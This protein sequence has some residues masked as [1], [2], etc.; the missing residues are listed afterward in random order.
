VYGTAPTPDLAWERRCLDRMRRG[1]HTAFGELY[2]VFAPKL[3]REVLMP[4]L[5]HA[6]LAEDALAD[7]FSSFLEHHAQLEVRDQSLMAWLARVATNKALDMHR[8]RASLL[9]SLASFESLIGPLTA[10]PTTDGTYEDRELRE[11]SALQVAR[12][13]EALNPRYRRALELR[14]FQDEP[15][16]RCAELLEVKLGT[17]DVLLLRAL[18]AFRREWEL[19]VKA[20]EGGQ[21]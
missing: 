10:S 16:E 9:R 17:F 8:K 5:G 20:Q 7:T 12:T 1:Q 3:Y 6:Q 4:K 11:L 13:L 18:R 14:F 15:R 2:R 19:S 21:P